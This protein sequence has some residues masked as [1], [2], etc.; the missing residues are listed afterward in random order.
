MRTFNLVEII[1]KITI[2][3]CNDV[4]VLE[5]NDSSDDEERPE[6]RKSSVINFL[7]IS[8]DN[9]KYL[10]IHQYAFSIVYNCYTLS[11]RSIHVKILLTHG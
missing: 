4:L 2:N 10:M 6:S 1:R 7:G 11:N 8:I 9:Y 3:L 5:Q